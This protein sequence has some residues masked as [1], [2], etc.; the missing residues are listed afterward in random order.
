MECPLYT[1][2]GYI[3]YSQDLLN[4]FQIIKNCF[5]YLILKQCWNSTQ[6][7]ETV[8][9]VISSFDVA[10]CF[11]IR[12]T[13]NMKKTKKQTNKK[14]VGFTYEVNP[15]EQETCVSHEYCSF[16]VGALVYWLWLWRLDINS[17]LEVS[18]STSISE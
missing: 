9:Q 8:Q 6:T 18:I 13:I 5:F 10:L 3:L 16:L 4:F 11:K 14:P 7:T 12:A 2:F 15:W 1:I 17:M